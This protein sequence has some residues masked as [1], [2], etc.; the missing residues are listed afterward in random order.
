[1]A[2]LFPIFVAMNNQRCVV[3]GGGQVAERKVE[4]LL[5]YSVHIDVISEALLNCRIGQKNI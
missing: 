2:D 3:V 5:E 1:M 4:N